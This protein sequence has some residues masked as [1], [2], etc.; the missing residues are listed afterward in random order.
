MEVYVSY[1]LMLVLV[2][3]ATATDYR[4]RRIP[5]RLLLG[6]LVVAAIVQGAFAAVQGWDLLDQGAPWGG[7]LSERG[8]PL[9]TNVAVA[10]LLALGLYA[11]EMVS[12]GDAKLLMVLAV[13]HPPGS[14]VIGPVPGAPHLRGT[15]S[16]HRSLRPLAL[17]SG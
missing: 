3:A 10:T 13:A 9:L 11:L 17:L 14:G 8:W 7:L 4:R 15:G 16:A 5:N 2:A 1:G 12:A 6:G